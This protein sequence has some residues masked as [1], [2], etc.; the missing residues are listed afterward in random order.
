MSFQVRVL[1]SSR[2]RARRWTTPRRGRRC[3]SPWD[4]FF[5]I[6]LPAP[7]GRLTTSYPFPARAQTAIK[8]D[9]AWKVEIQESPGV[10][11]SASRARLSTSSR[12]GVGTPRVPFPSIVRLTR[13]PSSPAPSPPAVVDVRQTWAGPCKAI[14][15]TFKRIFFDHGDKP[16]KFYT[17]DAS[18]VTA[19]NEHVGTCEPK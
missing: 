17:A 3:N 2:E 11:Q 6:R 18:K 9:E 1:A 10:L 5:S 8:D 14:Q 7:T 16:M 12:L 13:P 15:S 4:G 19:L